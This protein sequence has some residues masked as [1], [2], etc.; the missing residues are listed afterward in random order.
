MPDGKHGW[1]TGA[2]P[3]APGSAGPR[4]G[5]RSPGGPRQPRLRGAAVPVALVGAS[6][7]LVLLV[8]AVSALMGGGSSLIPLGARASATEQGRVL[9]KQTRVGQGGQ[10]ASGSSAT[11]FRPVSMEAETAGLGGTATAS[12]CDECSGGA[13]VRYIGGVGTGTVTFSGL[14]VPAAGTYHLTIGCV[15]DDYDHGPFLVSVNGGAPATVTC[16]LGSWSSATPK[17]VDITLQAGSNTIALGNPTM[18]APDL[19]NITVS[20]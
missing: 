16:P 4:F 3:G 9:D 11:G 20:Q 2:A 12:G 17:T 19:D 13:L 10:V 18:P 14:N 7:L 5:P 15:V 6:V 8:V 1:P